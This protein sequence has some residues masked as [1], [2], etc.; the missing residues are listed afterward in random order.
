MGLI[1]A[2]LADVSTE[3]KPLPG[4][5]YLFEVTEVQ[6]IEKDDKVIAYRVKSKVLEGEEEGR[7]FSDY[8]SIITKKDEINEVGLSNLKR[9]FEVTHGKAEVAGWSDDDYDT[10]RLVR[11]TFRAQLKIDSYTKEGETEPRMNNKIVRMDEV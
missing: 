3:F 6:E 1:N 7:A 5:I 10:D 4:G 11:K 2:S 9:Y 8:I